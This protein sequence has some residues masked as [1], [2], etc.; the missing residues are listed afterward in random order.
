M[1]TAPA[2]FKAA[3]YTATITIWS[4]YGNTPIT[5]RGGQFCDELAKVEVPVTDADD[6]RTKVK[7][8]IAS[9]PHGAYGHFNIKDHP[10]QNIRTEFVS[11]GRF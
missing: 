2:T 5:N 6:A 3:T 11:P 10:N 7:Q 8:L 4:Q 9:T 1:Q